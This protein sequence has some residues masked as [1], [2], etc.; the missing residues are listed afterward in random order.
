MT[1]PSVHLPMCTP[2]HKPAETQTQ[3]TT[4]NITHTLHLGTQ[5]NN[6]FEKTQKTFQ[7]LSKFFPLLPPVPLPQA[8]AATPTWSC[9]VSAHCCQ[10]MAEEG[11]HRLLISCGRQTSN[12]HTAG[13]TRGLLG[14]G[15]TWEGQQHQG[16]TL[17]RDYQFDSMLFSPTFVLGGLLCCQVN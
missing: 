7:G 2:C 8:R 5:R 3:K 17:V 9:C 11:G 10:G 14:M 6:S 16:D 15:A 4:P 1:H 13:M 12:I